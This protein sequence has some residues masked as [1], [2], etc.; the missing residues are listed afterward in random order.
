MVNKDLNGNG[1]PIIRLKG[2]L[3]IYNAIQNHPDLIPYLKSLNPPKLDFKN[4]QAL[5]LYNTYIAKDV[6]GLDIVLEHEQAI[7]PT[8][9]LRYNFLL[10]VIKPNSTIIE[11]GTGASAIIAMLAAKHFNAQ[12]YATE[13]DPLY[14]RIA[15]ENLIRNKLDN[16][17]SIIDSKGK[18]LE[19]VFPSDFKV[20]YIISNPPFY[21]KVR[22]T[23][24]LWGGKENE[25][26]SGNNGESFISSMIREGF[27]LLKKEGTIAF[28]ISNTRPNILNCIE[29]LVESLNCKRDII[30][31]K[32][33]TRTRYIYRIRKN[34]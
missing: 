5:L 19:G 6:Y 27:R 32:A 15:K 21:D 9:E 7:I 17:V 1:I 10:N 13:I 14:I 16:L 20:D 12:V 34:N 22:F 28:L 4:R 11:L 29:Q 33:G 18:I 2:G 25:L 30:C 31:L 3:P 24:V 8:P 23:K 26:V